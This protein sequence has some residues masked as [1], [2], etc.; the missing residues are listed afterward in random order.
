MGLKRIYFSK[1]QSIFTS[2]VKLYGFILVFFLGSVVKGQEVIKA[3]THHIA[4]SDTFPTPPENIHR[5]FYIQRTSN[6]HTVIYETNYNKD[7][8]INEFEP[9]KIYW[10]RYGNKGEILPLT[11]VQRKFAYGVNTMLVDKGKKMYKVNLVSFKKLD[12]YLMPS[13]IG[14]QYH[15]YV[16]INGKMS[17]LTKI[18]IKIDGGTLFNPNID[19]I[20]VT[21]KN[22]VTK[23]KVVERFKP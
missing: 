16:T 12:I 1:W 3:N 21:G 20:E 19:Y 17:L 23:H 13:K 2:V 5:L 14:K 10:I 18:F 4:I 22:I 7:S 6:L 11:P 9:V 15:A 8:T